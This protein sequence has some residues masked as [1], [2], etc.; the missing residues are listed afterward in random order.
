MEVLGEF[1]VSL[2]GNELMSAYFKASSPIREYNE[3]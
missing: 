3:L 2:G 1:I